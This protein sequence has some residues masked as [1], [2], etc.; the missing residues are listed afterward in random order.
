MIQWILTG[1]GWSNLP[2][3]LFC[4]DDS[5]WLLVMTLDTSLWFP[6]WPTDCFPCMAGKWPARFDFPADLESLFVVVH[7]GENILVWTRWRTGLSDL[8]QQH[9]GWYYYNYTTFRQCWGCCASTIHTHVK[10]YRRWQ[11]AVRIV[12]LIQ[13]RCILASKLSMTIQ[14]QIHTCCS[15]RNCTSDWF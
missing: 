10:E 11:S 6:V 8:Q 2:V 12:A 15:T 13:W 7:S 3:W 14:Y 5:W 9:Y 1:P 4:N